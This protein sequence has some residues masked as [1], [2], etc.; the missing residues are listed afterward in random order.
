MESK[1]EHRSH[2]NNGYAALH[3]DSRQDG[4]KWTKEAALALYQRYHILLVY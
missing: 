1:L 4:Q 2:V 3:V